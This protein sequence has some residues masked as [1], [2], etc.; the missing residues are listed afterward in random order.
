M[1]F[2][3]LSQGLSVHLARR[4]HS[5]RTER[6]EILRDQSRHQVKMNAWTCQYDILRQISLRNLTIP[7]CTYRKCIA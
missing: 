7:Q 2:F 6:A 5:H 1:L 3:T 4:R